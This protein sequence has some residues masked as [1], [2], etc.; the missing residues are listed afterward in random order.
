MAIVPTLAR[1]HSNVLLEGSRRSPSPAIHVLAQVAPGRAG[2]SRTRHGDS[3]GSGR[4]G[5]LF[6]LALGSLSS[7]L[8]GVQHIARERRRFHRGETYRFASASPE[9]APQHKVRRRRGKGSVL[10]GN[11]LARDRWGGGVTKTIEGY[12]ALRPAAELRAVTEA[13]ERRTKWRPKRET[14]SGMVTDK[15][16]E[17][18]GAL[19]V[20]QQ[21]DVLVERSLDMMKTNMQWVTGV[22][23]AVSDASLGDRR[24]AIRLT[25]EQTVDVKQGLGLVRRMEDSREL[26][27]EEVLRQ[28]SFFRTRN[29]FEEMYEYALSLPTVAGRSHAFTALCRNDQVELVDRLLDESHFRINSITLREA[30]HTLAKFGKV[31]RAIELAARGLKQEV[32]AQL[33]VEVLALALT[34]VIQDERERLGV[35][36]SFQVEGSEAM[37]QMVEKVDNSLPLLDPLRTSVRSTKSK[38]VSQGLTEAFN[39]LL[40]SCGRAMRVPLAF[41]VLRY[42]EDFLVSKDVYTYEAIGMNVVKRVSLLR[43]VWDLPMM[44]EEASPEVVFAGRSN[45]GKSSLVNMLLGRVALAPTSGRPGKTKTMDFF[46]VNAGH[47]TLPRF[48][49]VDVPGLGFARATREMRDRWVGLIGGYFVERKPLKLVFHLLDAGLGQVLP[50]DRD[51][52]KLLAQ[53][54]RT[55]FELCICLTKADNAMPSQVEHFAQIVREE[56]RSQ[57]SKLTVNA[58]IF[59]CSSKSKLGKDTLWN[60]I[61]DSVSEQDVDFGGLQAKERQ[62]QQQSGTKGWEMDK[63]FDENEVEDWEGDEPLPQVIGAGAD[64]AG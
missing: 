3:G 1:T 30:A 64:Q 43:K 39:E 60:K 58:T 6:K 11:K 2:V 34:A 50:A 22:V 19:A 51:L 29:Q 4:E 9:V 42:M 32:Q 59:A 5:L 63:H 31:D 38:I 40:L 44:P 8:C 37:Q 56:L 35:T 62:A 57:D 14:W 21:V 12:L 36:W 25:K 23:V 13:T 7:V 15:I 55:D 33:I 52:W 26:V 48:R 47:P 41:K 53:A 27:T 18:F 54:Q 49:L 28:V 10:R 46:D 24:V 45:V 17:E 61:W 20:G 16:E